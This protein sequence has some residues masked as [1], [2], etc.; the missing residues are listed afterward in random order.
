MCVSIH[1]STTQQRHWP[2]K[3]FE[4]INSGTSLLDFWHNRKANHFS[5]SQPAVVSKAKD[6]FYVTATIC[7]LVLLWTIQ[8][9]YIKDDRVD[10]LEVEED[11][12]VTGLCHTLLLRPTLYW[13]NCQDP[14]DRLVLDVERFCM[15]ALHTFGIRSSGML[16]CC[17]FICKV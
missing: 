11:T 8:H 9:K 13:S 15:N 16:L 6:D 14:N 7:S 17:V 12:R 10:P 3:E 4:T 1:L 2:G 5:A